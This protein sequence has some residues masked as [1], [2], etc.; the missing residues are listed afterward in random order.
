MGFVREKAVFLVEPV[1]EVAEQSGVGGYRDICR[2]LLLCFLQQI[3][4]VWRVGLAECVVDREFLGANS[5]FGCSSVHERSLRVL[6]R[7]QDRKNVTDYSLASFAIVYW[8]G[9]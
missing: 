3:S 7:F 1:M 6:E 8:I 9:E 2:I 5:E 4:N